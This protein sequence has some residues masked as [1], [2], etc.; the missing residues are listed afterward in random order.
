[1]AGIKADIP[2]SDD[3]AAIARAFGKRIA[4]ITKKFTHVC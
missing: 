1:V 4:E 2:I 3:E